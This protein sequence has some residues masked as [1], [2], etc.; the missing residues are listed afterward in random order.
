MVLAKFTVTP[1]FTSTKAFWGA[2]KGT[3]INGP[4][5][6]ITVVSLFKTIPS[7]VAPSGM[8]LGTLIKK[9]NGKSSKAPEPLIPLLGGVSVILHQ[10]QQKQALKLLHLCYKLDYLLHLTFQFL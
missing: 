8:K 9:L 4:D 1:Y 7:N 2:E 10:Y 6:F 5:A 3:L